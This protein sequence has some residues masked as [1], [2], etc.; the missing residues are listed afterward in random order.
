MN[1]T[2]GI[3]TN[4][5]NLSE[6]I[7]SI[8]GQI[9]KENFEIVIVGNCSIEP[10]D[11]IK[12]IPFDET[13]RGLWITKK[14]NLITQNASF[15]NIVYLHDY[16]KLDDNWYGGYK[17]FGNNWDVC[18][19]PIINLD[20]TRFRDLTT[21]PFY[22]DL[23]HGNDSHLSHFS[24]TDLHS[25]VPGM[26][27]FECLIPYDIDKETFNKIHDWIYISGAYW[28]AKKKVMEEYPLNE[29]LV[30]CQGEDLEWSERI[31]KKH[32]ISFNINSSVKLLKQKDVIFNQFT[33]NTLEFIKS[34]Y[35]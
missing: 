12:K 6:T 34:N 19:N 20:N 21:F 8:E 2:F 4:N 32:N 23:P 3:I 13:I 24:K 28:V 27:K 29:D 1:F 9:P 18:I 14:K 31:K 16:I 35:L 10:G 7:K 22:S 17:L 5:G 15:E 30:W 26:G 11:N 25:I 33:H